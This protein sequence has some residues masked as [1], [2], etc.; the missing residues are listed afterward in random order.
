M[1]IYMIMK[2]ILF[3]IGI[4]LISISI[5]FLIIYINLLNMGYT[6]SEYVNFI[7]RRLEI[8]AFIPGICL[9]IISM[10]KRK[11]NML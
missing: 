7:I 10:L 9:V 11:E 5:S 8:I 1:V 2:A 4:V 6:F 3:V